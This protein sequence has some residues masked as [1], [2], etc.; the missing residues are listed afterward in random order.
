[1]HQILRQWLHSLARAEADML[2]YAS[3]LSSYRNTAY[4]VIRPLSTTPVE[5]S[6]HVYQQITG[7]IPPFKSN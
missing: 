6:R 1:M 3:K 4:T 5:D 2:H 7:G